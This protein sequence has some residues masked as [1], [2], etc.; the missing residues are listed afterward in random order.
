MLAEE[1]LAAL[2]GRDRMTATKRVLVVDDDPAVSELLR[3]VLGNAGFDV[4]TAGDGVAGLLA[5]DANRP[6]LVILDVAMPAM[7][8][9][10]AVCRLRD[11]PGTAHLPI[12]M[13]TALAAEDILGGPTE[14]VDLYLAKPFD[15]DALVAA[16]KRILGGAGNLHE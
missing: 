15:P 13:L 10:E 9:L 11:R 1:W 12:I 7:D 4:A 3:L 8:G 6:D 5:I 14:Q 16:V 2:P